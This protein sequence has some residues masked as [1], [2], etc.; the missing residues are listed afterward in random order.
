MRRFRGQRGEG[1]FGCVIGLI[2]LLAGIFVAY[3]M[4]PIKVKAAEL[5]QE[6]V[7][8]AKSAGTHGDDRIRAAILAKAQQQGLPVSEGD[9]KI[10]RAGNNI[11][12]DVQYVVPV[13]F[14][15]FTYQWQFHHHAENP[16]F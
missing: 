5:R 14:P 6:V 11:T 1:Q 7:D 15:G 4:I 10:S 13:E 3:K 9:I 2:L 16:I 8:E 12:V